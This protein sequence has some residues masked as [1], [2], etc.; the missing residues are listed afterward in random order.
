MRSQ[1][2]LKPIETVAD[3]TLPELGVR[4]AHSKIL[5][6]LTTSD[7]GEQVV[8]KILSAGLYRK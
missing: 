8:H 6:T 4:L 2:E 1:I 3:H 5:A 7:I